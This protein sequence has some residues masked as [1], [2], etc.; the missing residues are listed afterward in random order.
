MDQQ[1]LVF[2]Y[3]TLRQTHGNHHLLSGAHCYGAGI[4]QAHYAMYMASGYP[5]VTSTEARYP[6]VGELYAVDNDTLIKL[7][8]MEGHPRYYT[9]K[10]IVVI[11]EGKEYNAWMYFRDPYGTLMQSGDFSD[12]V[13]RR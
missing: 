7:D 1:H 9:R 11:V 2:V 3:G 10:E 8:K 4:T 12:A 6:I 5:Y 13:T